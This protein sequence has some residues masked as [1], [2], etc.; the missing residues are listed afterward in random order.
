[1][2]TVDDRG[3]EEWEYF[4]DRPRKAPKLLLALGLLAVLGLLAAGGAW[5]WFQRQ[6]DPPG[7]PG[8]P[9]AVVVPQGSSPRR[10]A[11][12][13][14]DKGI[15]E[16]AQVFSLYVRL[17]SPGTFRAGEYTF[18][19]GSSFSDIIRALE[20]GPRIRYQR[21]TVPEGLTLEQIAERVGTLPGRSADRFLELA[22][23]GEIRSKYQPEDVTSLEGLLFPETYQFVAR[24]DEAA[25]LQRMVDHFDAVLD[26]LDFEAK[27]R[28]RNVDPY[29]AIVAASLIERETRVDDER[30]KIARVIYNRLRAKMP[31]Q[32]DATVIYA[33]GESGTK[34]R[35]LFKDLE[36]DSPY[37][38]YKVR[39]LPPTPIAAS[40]R[41]SLAAAVAPAD[42]P[43][44][45]YVVTEPDGRHSFATTLRE[46]NQNIAKAKANGLR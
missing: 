15:I 7:P 41:A 31:L 37:N 17:N 36:V 10:I 19:T 40:S 4:P 27:A 20:R 24:D 44:I 45:Y 34:T 23:S 14:D 43:W 28:A 38:T 1:M 9:V 39:G 6:I 2:R 46:H 3:Q 8:E 35:V 21:V 25:I 11:A 12:I 5:L 32:I 16:S 29:E 33:L 13:L 42:G 18:R 30:P 26:E 22:R